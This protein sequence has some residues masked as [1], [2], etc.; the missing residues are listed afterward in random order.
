MWFTDIDREA[1]LAFQA[2][3]VKDY[4]LKLGPWPWRILQFYYQSFESIV[5]ATLS[6]KLWEEKKILLI[7]DNIMKIE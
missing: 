6:S 5:F 3:G 7:I 4:V 2:V 1:S